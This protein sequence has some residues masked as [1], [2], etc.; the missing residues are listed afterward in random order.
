MNIIIGVIGALVFFCVG[1]RIIQ[2][3]FMILGGFVRSYD[4]KVVAPEQRPI[5]NPPW[6]WRRN[7][8]FDWRE[9]MKP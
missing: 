3:I 7:R 1:I 5:F 2:M 6:M 9:G 8:N 4:P